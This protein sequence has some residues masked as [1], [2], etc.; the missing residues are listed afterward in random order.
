[1]GGGGGS[2][3]ASGGGGSSSDDDGDASWKAAI[4]SIAAEGFGVPLSNGAAKVASGSGGGEANHGVEP[5]PQEGK[6]KAPRLKL[7]QIKVSL[8]ARFSLLYAG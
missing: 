4:E 3:T 7:Y 8:F 1:M 6:E 5:S 2:R